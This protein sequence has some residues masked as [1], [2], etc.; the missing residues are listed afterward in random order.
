MPGVD[1]AGKLV[2]LA[3][4]ASNLG[5]IATLII[6]LLIFGALIV[7]LWLRQ[8]NQYAEHKAESAADRKESKER[9]EALDKIIETSTEAFK[10]MKEA[11]DKQTEH[12][13]LRTVGS[14]TLVRAI[15]VQGATLARLEGAFTNVLLTLVHSGHVGAIGGSRRLP[16][17]SLPIDPAPFEGEGHD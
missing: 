12:I 8:E 13:I 16:P 4:K 7:F 10:E 3:E 1:E 15:E 14:D 6:F 2:D 17:S 9:E 5:V 11:L